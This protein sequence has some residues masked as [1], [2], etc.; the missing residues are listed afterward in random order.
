MLD[1][2]KNYCS[3]SYVDSYWKKN[4]VIEQ[5]KTKINIEDRKKALEDIIRKE[6]N[7]KNDTEENYDNFQYTNIIRSNITRE[8]YNSNQYKNTGNTNKQKSSEYRTFQKY[9]STGENKREKH[10]LPEKCRIYEYNQRERKILL[11]SFSKP[12]L[13]Y[14]TNIKN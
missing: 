12:K 2:D 7:L 13:L 14:E 11:D 10:N 8:G 3:S 9:S 4:S 5:S 6:N 1:V